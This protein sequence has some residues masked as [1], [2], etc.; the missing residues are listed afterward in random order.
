MLISIGSDHAGFSLK[1]KVKTYLESVRKTQVK[2]FGTY[3]TESCD[4]PDFIS[5]AALA[6]A[7]GTAEMGIVICGSGIGASI[8]ANK[9]NGIRAALCGSSELAS[10]S[11]KHNNANILALG[12]RFTTFIE[13]INIIESFF[14]AEFEKGRHI[15]RIRKISDLES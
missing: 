8:V 11:R 9:I 12:S 7:K 13:A 3:S 6:V 2:D 1:E 10:L 4:Y 15:D 5:K 14:T